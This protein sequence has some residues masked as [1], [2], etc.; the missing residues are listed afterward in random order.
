MRRLD[1]HGDTLRLKV[2][3]DAI[4]DFRGQ[5][6]LHLQAPRETVQ[7]PGQLGNAHHPVM[8]QVSDRRLAD[9]RRHVMLAMRLERDVL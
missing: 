5:A 4:G 3:P 7:H 1:N 9:D 6:F 8:G 2:L